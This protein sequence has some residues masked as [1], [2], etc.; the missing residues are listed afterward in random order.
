MRPLPA[1]NLFEVYPY[2][3]LLLKPF[4][5]K[6]YT[7]GLLLGVLVLFTCANAQT[8][9][10]VRGNAYNVSLT[11]PSLRLRIP[12]ELPKGIDSS[13]LRTTLL[14]V[15]SEQFPDS[16]S[17]SAFSNVFILHTQGNYFLNIDISNDPVMIPATYVLNIRSTKKKGDGAVVEKYTLTIIV[18][19]AVIAPPGTML[20]ER[21]GRLGDGFDC[22]DTLLYLRETGRK[23]ALTNISLH[24][25]K[26]LDEKNRPV[27]GQIN[28]RP[29]QRIEAGGSGELIFDI[30]GEFPIGKTTAT[31]E[32]NGHQLASPI[33]LTVEI[34]TRR[35]TFFLIG[36]LLSGLL[37]GY[38]VRI[39][40][41]KIIAIN[42]ARLPGI[43]LLAILDAATKNRLDPT[44]ISTIEAIKTDFKTGLRKKNTEDVTKAINDV[45]AAL[46]KAISDF[47]V[48][49]TAAHKELDT[50]Q[51]TV[52]SIAT[53]PNQF[54][55]IDVN[56]TTN[57]AAIDAKLAVGHIKDANTLLLST[58]EKLT[59]AFYPVLKKY[60][61]AC[62]NLLND[63]KHA[64]FTIPEITTS[65]DELEAQLKGIDVVPKSAIDVNMFT[66]LPGIQQKMGDLLYSA[67]RAL[68]NTMTTITEA[69]KQVELIL[70]DPNKIEELGT[71]SDALVTEIN[72]ITA[73][74][75][76]YLS[77][78]PDKLSHLKNTLRSSFVAQTDDEGEPDK[79]KM[80]NNEV[81]RA[82]IEKEIAAGNYVAAAL[83]VVAFVQANPSK[84]RGSSHAE[85]ANLVNMIHPPQAAALASFP[86]QP[87]SFH[88]VTTILHNNTTETDFR[89]EKVERVVTAARIT[90]AVLVGAVIVFV[91]YTLNADSFIGTTTEIASV[92]FWSF[93]INISLTTLTDGFFSK[94]IK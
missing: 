51:N 2:L 33:P 73:E 4:K 71:E 46:D 60:R 30:K 61:Q 29:G 17:I 63:L 3:Q 34:T 74:P 14:D 5:M 82:A 84:S 32:L 81:A 69:F 21:R 79:E 7:T 94:I 86:F 91:G 28:L 18:N 13:K 58:S 64:P 43:E 39:L 31:L 77:T 49:L 40:L 53:L 59:E 24:R 72:T 55:A 75:E 12:I 37:A 87:R 56:V 42:E 27:S 66:T 6:S 47:N 50:L 19:P 52:N 20:V 1:T 65:I 15:H 68:R 89:F 93:L 10:F 9:S 38:L 85:V 45:K 88:T 83:A 57:I 54:K 26:A 41:T 90:Q 92:F 76:T 62:L 11:G 22:T 70:P 80:K 48:Q 36:L 35:G 44:F 8:I 23:S 25:I 16:V 67:G 78:L